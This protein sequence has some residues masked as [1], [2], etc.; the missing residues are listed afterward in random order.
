MHNFA[1]E[2][3]DIN[4]LSRVVVK[5]Y[6][7]LGNYLTPIVTSPGGAFPASPSFLYLHASQIVTSFDSVIGST[8]ATQLTQIDFY[9]GLP[10][11]QPSATFKAKLFSI[12]EELQVTLVRQ[13]EMLVRAA[14][15]RKHQRSTTTAVGLVLEDGSDVEANVDGD[16]KE[17]RPAKSKRLS[18]D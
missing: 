12:D 1:S 14:R 10:L 8:A 5:A 13:A 16:G 9:P 2:C 18:D 15:S 4:E 6:S 11:L 3:Q 7:E 17:H